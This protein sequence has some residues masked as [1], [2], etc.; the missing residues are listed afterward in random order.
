M[1]I[2]SSY[3]YQDPTFGKTQV[4]GCP[5]HFSSSDP[6]SIKLPVPQFGEHTEEVLQDILGYGWDD[7]TQLKDEEVI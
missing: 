5:V 3:W 4:A 1:L 7:I 6:A 2:K